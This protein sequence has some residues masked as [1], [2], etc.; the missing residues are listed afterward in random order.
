MYVRNVFT[1]M[2]VFAICYDAVISTNLLL[3]NQTHK[4][5][6]QSLVQIPSHSNIWWTS[7]YE[8][9]SIDQWACRL[10]I[11]PRVIFAPLF[12]CECSFEEGACEKQCGRQQASRWQYISATVTCRSERCRMANTDIRREKC[13]WQSRV[14]DKPTNTPVWKI[15]AWAKNKQT[16]KKPHV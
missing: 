4:P 15:C 10:N 5:R 16:K 6:M 1:C 8:H 9:F 13:P 3:S 12:W 7:R 14:S 2:P 11:H